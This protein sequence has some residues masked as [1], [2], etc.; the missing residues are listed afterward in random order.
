MSIISTAPNG[1]GLQSRALSTYRKF[2]LAA[3]WG[4]VFWAGISHEISAWHH[5][6]G[7][8]AYRLSLESDHPKQDAPLVGDTEVLRL[9][10]SS[11]L[12]ITLRPARRATDRVVLQ[13]FLVRDGQLVAWPVR[14]EQAD[15]GT[16]HLRAPVQELPN[17]QPGKGHLFFLVSVRPLPRFFDRAW[18]FVS[19]LGWW[20]PL[21]ILSCP[22]EITAP[23]SGPLSR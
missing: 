12:Q 18:D 10:P 1:S 8:P 17:L 6:D 23:V 3:F 11:L 21:Q 7:A 5:S 2:L 13:T 19:L 16:F 4:P 14:F 15:T 20:R 22:F 9:S